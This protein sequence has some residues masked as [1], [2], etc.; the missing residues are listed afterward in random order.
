[1]RVGNDQMGRKNDDEIKGRNV[2]RDRIKGHLR[3]G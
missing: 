2:G 1:M 3:N